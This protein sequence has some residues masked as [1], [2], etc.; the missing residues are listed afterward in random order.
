M[1]ADRHTAGI[2]ELRANV[3]CCRAKLAALPQDVPAQTR[4]YFARKLRKVERELYEE[5]CRLAAEQE[6]R[7]YMRAPL[8]LVGGTGG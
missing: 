6:A 5:R 1:V 3:A 8:Q 4:A 7:R 2:E